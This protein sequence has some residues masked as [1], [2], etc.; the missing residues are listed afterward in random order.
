MMSKMVFN[1]EDMEVAEI[2]EPVWVPTHPHVGADGIYV[3]VHPYVREDEM[4]LYKLLISRDMF[5]EAYNMWING[6]EDNEKD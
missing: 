2:K 3:P 1:R 5:V 4:P 6:D